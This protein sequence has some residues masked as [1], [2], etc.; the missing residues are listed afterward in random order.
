MKK[1]I[2]VDDEPQIL[3]FIQTYFDKMVDEN[4]N[5]KYEIKI[6]NRAESCIEF[7]KLEGRA[8]LILSDMR[9]PEADGVEILQFIKENN[10]DIPLFFMTGFSGDYNYSDMIN[11]GAKKVFSKPFKFSSL[12]QEIDTYLNQPSTI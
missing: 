1:I 9:M 3:K 4:N 6:F 2:V 5:K 10:I 11:L 7:L 8:D 12:Y